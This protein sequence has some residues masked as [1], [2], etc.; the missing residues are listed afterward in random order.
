M[1]YAECGSNNMS[2]SMPQGEQCVVVCAEWLEGLAQCR[3]S[4]CITFQAGKVQPFPLWIQQI[5]NEFLIN[6]CR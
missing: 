3:L 2:D 1:T 4:K 5:L 6:M